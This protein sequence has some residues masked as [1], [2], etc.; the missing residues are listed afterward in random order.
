MARMS[1]GR[2]PVCSRTHDTRWE[3][4][5]EFGDSVD[6]HYV[7]WFQKMESNRYADEAAVAYYKISFRARD[8]RTSV[9]LATVSRAWLHYCNASLRYTRA[10]GLSDMSLEQARSRV[11][12]EHCEPGSHCSAHA[13]RRARSDL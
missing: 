7:D 8:V 6:T 5:D 10:F 9:P 4:E 13:A 11:Q 2:L 3:E 12:R 1:T